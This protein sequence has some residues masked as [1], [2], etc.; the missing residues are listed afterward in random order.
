M[1]RPIEVL[2]V[3]DD[4]A[5]GDLVSDA[6]ER[7]ADWLSVR[8]ETNAADALERIEAESPDCVVSDYEMPEMDGIE[9]LGAVREEHPELPFILFT[10]QGSEAVASEAM[11]AGATEYLQKTTGS[12][13]YE[14]L[15]N[16]IRNAVEKYRSQ[17]RLERERS[18][19]QFALESANAAIWTRD[20]ETDGME[21]HPTVC[22]VFDTPI[23]CFDDFLAEV[24]PADRDSVEETVRSAAANGD[25]YSMQFRFP[26][27]DGTRWGEMNGRT[28]HEDGTPAFQTGITRDITPQ[29]E[30]KRR[31]ETL[32]SNL[33]GMVYRCR[34]EPGW[35]MEDVRGDVASFTGYTAT[36]LETGTVQW[37]EQVLHPD[38][39][40][41]IW[42]AVQSSLE[43][44]GSF[45]VTYRIRTREGETRWAWERGHGIY[46][47]DDQ[48]EALE[49]FITDITDQKERERRLERQ[50][51]RFDEL[52]SVV[53][54]DL[55]TPLSVAR[56]RLKLAAETGDIEHIEEARSSL[57]RLDDLRED[58]VGLLRTGDIVSATER[59]DVA[60]LA[61]DAWERV[62]APESARLDAEDAPR[63]DGDPD[64]IRRLLQNLLSNSVEHGREDGDTTI[65][66]GALDDGFYVEDDGPGIPPED[67]K[68]VFTPGFTTKTGGT[69]MGMASVAGVVDAHGWDIDITDAE[70]LDGVRFEIRE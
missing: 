5:F 13:Q 14:L 21:I 48:L 10:G 56:G 53:S 1:A 69:G 16:R 28:I 19:M 26:G 35:P 33:P 62:N 32:I 51:E 60:T 9:F 25:A 68:D 36:E 30:R 63:T 52:A 8:T 23:D 66:V 40:E 57:D 39:S 6:L 12:N 18:R 49:G 17:K 42:E 58:L 64:A 27:T 34:N 46:G 31:F 38:D 54:H 67:R 43:S 24:H 7:E 70:E 4:A 2:H 22:P 45:E 29:K 55:Q 59:V 3:D 47:P 44:T 50:N 41:W 37:G 61:A 65:R 11:S 20:I 15:A